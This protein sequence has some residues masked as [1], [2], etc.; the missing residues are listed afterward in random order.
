VNR[1]GEQAPRRLLESMAREDLP[2][3]LDGLPLWESAFQLAGFDLGTV[4][5][6]FFG[7]LESWG[8]R[9]E[10]TIGELPRL[11]GVVEAGRTRVQIRVLGDPPLPAEAKVAVRFRPT[12]ESDSR[13]YVTTWSEGEEAAVWLGREQIAHDTVCFQPGLPIGGAILYEAWQCQPVAWRDDD[14]GLLPL[15]AEPG[16][17]RE[18]R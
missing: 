10:K 2:E 16:E 17:S 7:L 13:A 9:H 4:A 6:E 14:D 8:R 3:D 5:D 1:H 15:P 11:R 12:A 18:P